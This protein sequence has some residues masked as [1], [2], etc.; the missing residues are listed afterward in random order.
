MRQSITSLYSVLATCACGTRANTTNRLVILYRIQSITYIYYVP[1]NKCIVHWILK[2]I[3]RLIGSITRACGTRVNAN[4]QTHDI[5]FQYQMN[6][7]YVLFSVC[8][9]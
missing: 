9:L 7:T 4:Q 8:I 1:D 6:N 3:I 2:N 5:N